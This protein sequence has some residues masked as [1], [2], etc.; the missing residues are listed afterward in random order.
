[1]EEEEASLSFRK[2]IELKADMAEDD[3]DDDDNV[4]GEI[5]FVKKDDIMDQ[6]DVVFVE[7]VAAVVAS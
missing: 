3:D 4:T 7:E 2:D 1:V 6:I 5:R